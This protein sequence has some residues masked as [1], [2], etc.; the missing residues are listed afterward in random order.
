[1]PPPIPPM[2]PPM[3]PMPP[4]WPV[5]PCAIRPGG[6][7]TRSGRRVRL[8]IVTDMRPSLLPSA[9]TVISPSR[10]AFR[11]L[12]SGTSCSA[13]AGRLSGLHRGLGV[14]RLRWRCVLRVSGHA[15]AMRQQYQQANCE[16]AYESN[17]S[18]ELSFLL[19]SVTDKSP[20]LPGIFLIG[21]IQS[22]NRSDDVRFQSRPT[23]TSRNRFIGALLTVVPDQRA[24]GSAHDR[25]RSRRTSDPS[26]RAPT[27]RISPARGRVAAAGN[28][29]QGPRCA[30]EHTA[31]PGVSRADQAGSTGDR[32]MCGSDDK[33]SEI[34]S[35]AMSVRAPEPRRAR[36]H[37]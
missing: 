9:L 37:R 14:L 21:S 3:P 24:A 11:R 19:I 15:L 36:T 26:S 17:N 10:A 31:W 20:E 23:A 6:R 1:M 8:V 30:G 29:W 18:W 33:T 7:T 5:A 16:A 27:G 35:E 4:I 2:P 25:A 22:L 34:D 28:A 13:F 12:T 32:T